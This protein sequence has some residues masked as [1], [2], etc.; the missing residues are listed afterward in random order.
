[1]LE[2]GTG[3]ESESSGLP[4][5]QLAESGPTLELFLRFLLKTGGDGPRFAPAENYLDARQ[6]SLLLGLHAAATKYEAW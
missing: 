3:H 1:M 6:F 5:V 2:V 4:V